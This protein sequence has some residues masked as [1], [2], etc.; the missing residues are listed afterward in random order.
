MPLD[1]YQMQQRTIEAQRTEPSGPTVRI[2]E[3]ERDAL[4]HNARLADRVQ[5]AGALAADVAVQKATLAALQ[6]TRANVAAR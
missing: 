6:R 5:K 1:A 4:Q 3:L 2:A